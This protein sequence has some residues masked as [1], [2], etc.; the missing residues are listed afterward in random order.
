MCSTPVLAGLFEFIDRDRDEVAEFFPDQAQVDRARDQME[1]AR[2]RQ[3]RD[4]SEH[5]QAVKPP[6]QKVR[7]RD[8]ALADAERRRNF[9]APPAD[10]RNLRVRCRLADDPEAFDHEPGD[11]DQQKAG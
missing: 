1:E 11:A 4:K 6:C 8:V 3:R 10:K 5:Q 7:H 2:E 9:G